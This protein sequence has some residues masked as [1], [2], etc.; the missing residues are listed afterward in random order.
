M[1]LGYA[2]KKTI[3]PSPPI[4]TRPSAVP[5]QLI[6]CLTVYECENKIRVGNKNDGGYV[7]SDIEGY[8]ILLAGGVG[9]D[10]GFENWVT[11]NQNLIK[12]QQKIYN[13][14]QSNFDLI[15]N[16]LNK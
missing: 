14:T 2:K 5:K 4:P 12:S 1:M 7:I 16:I 10:I 13:Q 6:E 3:G 8:D 9:N 11:N 15:N